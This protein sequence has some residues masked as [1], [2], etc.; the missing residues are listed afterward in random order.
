M[1]IKDNENFFP[2]IS[3]FLQ[4]VKNTPSNS[5]AKSEASKKAIRSSFV[6]HKE[7]MRENYHNLL[8]EDYEDDF[9]QRL[10][11]LF[12]ENRY[13]EQLDFATNMQ[14]FYES[15]ALLN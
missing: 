1:K 14:R 5:S 7:V 10:E 11:A 9:E 15:S 6:N 12:A 4:T 3:Q 8:I 13:Y 2:G